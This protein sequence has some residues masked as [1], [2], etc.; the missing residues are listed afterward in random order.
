MKS[1]IFYVLGAIGLV[2]SALYAIEMED[3]CKMERQRGDVQLAFDG[4]RNKVVLGDEENELSDR[5]KKLLQCTVDEFN[6]RF[7]IK[8]E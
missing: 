7:N 3:R 5:S 6:E 2:G 1:V 8:D 4:L